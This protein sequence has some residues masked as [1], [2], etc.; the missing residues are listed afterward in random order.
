M[1]NHIL[2]GRRLVKHYF[3]WLGVGGGG[4]CGIIFAGWGG[5]RWVERYFGWLGMGWKRFWV[6]EVGRGWARVGGGGW[7]EQGWL[8]CLIIPI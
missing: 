7:G 4:V 6:G 5:W 1:L 8:H 3:E 2:C